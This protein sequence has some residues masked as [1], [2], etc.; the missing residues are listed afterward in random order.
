MGEGGRERGE[1][2]INGRRHAPENMREGKAEKAAKRPE[3]D[4]NDGER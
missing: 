3:G 4:R 1:G 2:L